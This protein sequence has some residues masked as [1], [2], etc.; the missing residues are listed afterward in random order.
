[1]HRFITEQ[2]RL[3]NGS[4]CKPLISVSRGIML[5][6]FNDRVIWLVEGIH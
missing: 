5:F 1:M 2:F 6:I 3:N 4:Q